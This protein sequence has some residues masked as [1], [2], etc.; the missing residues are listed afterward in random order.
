MKVTSKTSVIPD[1]DISKW[2]QIQAIMTPFGEANVW[3]K[4]LFLSLIQHPDPNQPPSTSSTQ[5][6]LISSPP[7]HTANTRK[8]ILPACVVFPLVLQQVFYNAV[9]F[10]IEG[11]PMRTLSL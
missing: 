8:A 1:A 7:F 10:K 9:L 11:K 4:H 2:M 3:G 6:P 5:K